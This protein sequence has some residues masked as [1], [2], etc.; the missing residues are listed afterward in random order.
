[1]R[2]KARPS[3]PGMFGSPAE[4][5]SPMARLAR[6]SEPERSGELRLERALPLAA[7]PLGACGA[8]TL[9]GRHCALLG[10]LE[11]VSIRFK[12]PRGIKVAHVLWVEEHR[13]RLRAL[14]SRQPAHEQRDAAL[15]ALSVLHAE[16]GGDA[17]VEMIRLEH[18]VNLA[19][20]EHRPNFEAAFAEGT[21]DLELLRVPFRHLV[22]RHFCR[23]ILALRLHHAGVRLIEAL[24]GLHAQLLSP[25]ALL[26][27]PLTRL[28]LLARAC[29]GLLPTADL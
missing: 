15:A 1:M 21:A 3:S 17:S 11:P 2:M 8:R 5:G 16:L 28:A 24:L 25:L 14:P 23:L 4:D 27:Y 9:L 22:R 29:F 20:R 26:G 18:P 6:V 7:A 19:P 13:L 10:P 12:P